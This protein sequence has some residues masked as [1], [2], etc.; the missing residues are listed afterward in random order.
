MLLQLRLLTYSESC[1]RHIQ[2][3]KTA[4]TKGPACVREQREIGDG[5]VMML[6]LVLVLD[7]IVVMFKI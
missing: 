4:T 6:A 1:W 2:S 7:F 5:F 3:V